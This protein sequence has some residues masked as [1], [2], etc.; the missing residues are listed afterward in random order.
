MTIETVMVCLALD[1]PNQARLAEIVEEGDGYDAARSRLRDVVAWLARHGMTA[2]ERIGEPKRQGGA[3]AALD[4]IAGAVGAGLIAAGACGHSRFRE[5]IVGGMT[6]H[7][8]TQSMRCVR[9]SH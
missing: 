2:S 4:E 9:L 5:L 1:Q 8:L 7:L 6:Q 3:A